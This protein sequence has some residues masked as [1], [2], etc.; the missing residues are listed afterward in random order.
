[1]EPDARGTQMSADDARGRMLDA[2]KRLEAWKR[3]H[4]YYEIVYRTPS[5]TNGEIDFQV[6]PW[7]DEDAR[8]LHQLQHAYLA[9]VRD[10]ERTTRLP[11]EPPAL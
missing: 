1:M 4:N 7:T 6:S 2:S 10:Y 5:S 8:E 9:A 3:Q 11:G